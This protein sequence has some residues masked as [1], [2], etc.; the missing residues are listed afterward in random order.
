VTAVAR[1]IL[2]S[3][4]EASGDLYGGA[5]VSALRTL[6]PAISVSGFG[7]GHLEAAGARLLGDSRGFSVTGL[8]EALRVL[9]RSWRMLGTIR[10]AAARER[11]DVFVAI[12]FPDFNFR[13]LPAMRQL[14]VPIVYYV[15]PQLWAWRSSRIET[16]SAMWT[17]LAIPVLSADHGRPACRWSLSVIRWCLAVPS[18][19]RR[20]AAGARRSNEPSSRCWAAPNELQQ[21]LPT[22][23]G[24]RASPADAPVCSS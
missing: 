8:V 6:D 23:S 3:C 12:D 13:L 22:L 9:P 4:G 21:I 7:G 2:I 1:R 18:R 24:G 11:P 16:I 19:D 5:L 14:G 20:R 17:V 15:S 10:R